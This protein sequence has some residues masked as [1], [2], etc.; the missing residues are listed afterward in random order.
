LMAK[1]RDVGL[2]VL[3][4]IYSVA[5][6]AG[7]LWG[8][9]WLYRHFDSSGLWGSRIVTFLFGLAG[10]AFGLQMSRQV[11]QEAERK[12]ID[13]SLE[14]LERHVRQVQDAGATQTVPSIRAADLSALTKHTDPEHALAILQCVNAL[15]RMSNSKAGDE[16]ERP[17]LTEIQDQF[18]AP[19]MLLLK[20]KRHWL[21]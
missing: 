11:A 5:V 8:G 20:T 9:Y 2:Q 18:I 13:R 10:S 16:S 6:L 7:F 14:V 1:L 15:E 3:I 12:H 21:R 19:V 17:R 4:G